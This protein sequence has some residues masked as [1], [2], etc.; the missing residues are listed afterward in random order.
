M[1]RRTGIFGG[2]AVMAL[3]ALLFAG[4]AGAAFPG[5]NG[6]IAFSQ[7]LA[8]DAEGSSQVFTI[9]PN[10]TGLTQLTHVSP[11]QHAG[12]PDLSPDGQRIV[13]H[14]NESGAF[15][16]WVMNADGTG[17]TQLTDED[18]YEDFQPSWS[19]DGSRIVFSHCPEPFG[20]FASVCNIAVMKA[21][22]TGLHSI[23]SS[24][25]WNNLHP[26]YSPNGRRIAFDSDRGGRQSAVWVMRA[27][28]SS[29]DR[30]T[31]TRLRAFWADWAPD[32]HHILFSDNCCLPSS[33]LWT[34]RPDG[35]E[36]TQL[37]HV[38]QS[39]NLA[40]GVYS[41]N[42]RRIVASFSRG[43]ADA[44]CKHLYVLHADGSHPHKL[45]TGQ[46]DTLAS[47]WGPGG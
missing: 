9:K 34:V 10:G 24:G 42:G 35:S 19:P 41:P 45:P 6:K 23:R 17:Q 25:N 31:P 44:P 39:L 30:L 21:N 29:P 46:P 16:I 38:P 14:S 7:G 33:N 18:G 15:H 1:T 2:V 27:N 20:F 3:A 47:D 40:F 12:V 32:G 4:P 11:D 22:G 28:G 26:V 13:Y 8:P 37:T 36:L 5:T 43:C